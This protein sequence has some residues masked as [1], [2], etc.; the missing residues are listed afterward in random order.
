MGQAGPRKQDQ[1]D[2]GGD[3]GGGVLLFPATPC[4]ALCLLSK[5]LTANE[6]PSSASERE[7]IKVT[8]F[9]PV[10]WIWLGFQRQ[11]ERRTGQDC[12]KQCWRWL[13]Q[14][15]GSEEP[16]PGLTAWGGS[17]QILDGWETGAPPSLFQQSQCA[18]HQPAAFFLTRQNIPTVATSSGL[19]DR[20]PWEH[21]HWT[22]IPLE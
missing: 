11:W 13:L 19:E 18:R 1:L 2:Q 4:V 9:P 21:S 3:G 12:K 17:A 5:A 7:K 14:A 8:V 22:E 6:A 15:L 16:A 20:A 10:G